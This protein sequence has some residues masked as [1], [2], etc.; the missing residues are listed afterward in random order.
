MELGSTLIRLHWN[1]APAIKTFRKEDVLGK[2]VIETSGAV[3]GKVTD[4]M[5]DLGG[6]IVLVVRGADGA[7]SEVKISQVTGI[8]EHV[9][10]RAEQ[11]QTTAGLRTRCKFCGAA[12]APEAVWCPACGRSQL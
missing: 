12:T 9:V 3:R 1:S 8:S 7:E 5:F 10:V 4:V 11:G 2:T 6:V